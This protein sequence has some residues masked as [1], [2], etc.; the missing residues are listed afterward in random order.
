MEFFVHT[1]LKKTIHIKYHALEFRNS[2]YLNVLEILEK[3][4]VLVTLWII[5]QSVTFLP[6]TYFDQV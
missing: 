3:H 1:T 6:F 4:G 5:I 2:I